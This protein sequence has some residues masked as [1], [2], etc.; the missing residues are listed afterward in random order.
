MP[1]SIP[2]PLAAASPAQIHFPDSCGQLQ[3]RSE[4]S[5]GNWRRGEWGWGAASQLSTLWPFHIFASF[6]VGVQQMDTGQAWE[7]SLS[8]HSGMPLISSHQN[9][10]AACGQHCGVQAPQLDQPLSDHLEKV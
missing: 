5:R 2:T 8:R 1:Y 6:L 10:P 9:P 4:T 7:A 3:L